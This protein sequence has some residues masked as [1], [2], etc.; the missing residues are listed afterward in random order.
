[1]NC[2]FEFFLESVI[3]ITEPN[4]LQTT[5]ISNNI[6]Y[7]T[8]IYENLKIKLPINE[9]LYSKVIMEELFSCKKT[10]PYYN[11]NNLD[12]DMKLISELNP[13]FLFDIVVHEDHGLYWELYSSTC[14]ENRT[15]AYHKYY[16]NGK[17]YVLNL[18]E[19]LYMD[20]YMEL[21]DFEN[22]NWQ[23]ITV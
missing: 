14:T 12:K 13:S 15:D 6:D 10:K 1:M 2:K 21:L 17:M 22:V 23:D 4:F 20:D 11:Y 7:K 16:L 19:A 9:Q 3:D 18:L 5:L 8:I